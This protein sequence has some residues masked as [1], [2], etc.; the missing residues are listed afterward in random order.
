MTI[1][2]TR[3]YCKTK[4]YEGEPKM[5]YRKP[6]KSINWEFLTDAF[7]MISIVIILLYCLIHW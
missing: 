1:S 7:A 2:N 5:L 4:N 3:L 6:K